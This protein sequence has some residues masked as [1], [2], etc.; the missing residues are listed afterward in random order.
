M[1]A[2][3][4]RIAGLNARVEPMFMSTREYMKD[5]LTES[6]P[7]IRIAP[8]EADIAFEQKMLDQEAVEEGMKLR[9]FTGPFL[10]RAAIQ[11][12]VAEALLDRET[13]L[14]HGS[15]VGLDG[16]AYLFTAACGTGKSTH[17]RLW[18]QVF[19]DRAVMVND[20]KP[21][22]RIGVHGAV[23]YGSPWAGK[24]GLH[25]NICLPVRGICILRRGPENRIRRSDPEG[26]W[27]FLM[28]QTLIPE[29][30]DLAQKAETLLRVLVQRIPFWEM[31]CNQNPEAAMVSFEAMSAP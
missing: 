15:T 21:F 19:G 25:S 22:L 1:E 30:P 4:I 23:A 2:F 8:S 11:R 18:R 6:E 17:T 20:D 16:A 24:H 14:L 13:I 29:D 3:T 31:E 9:K 28:K 7:D 10:E 27:N 5:Y 26:N 12:R